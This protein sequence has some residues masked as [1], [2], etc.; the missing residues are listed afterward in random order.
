MQKVKNEVGYSYITIKITKSRINKGLLAIPV[1]LLDKFPV[2]NGHS[3]ENRG[4]LGIDRR[5]ASLRLVTRLTPSQLHDPPAAVSVPCLSKFLFSGTR[6]A[7][8]RCRQ[9]TRSATHR[10]TVLELE[11]ATT[12]P[13]Q[14]QFPIAANASKGIT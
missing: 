4:V 11:P 1:S 10:V 12:C 2:A 3:T 9:Y 13:H 8:I 14:H 7:V 5:L 6:A